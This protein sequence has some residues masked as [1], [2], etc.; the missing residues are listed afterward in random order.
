VR[1]FLEELASTEPDTPGTWF[2]LGITLRD[3]GLLIGDCGIRF[4]A[5]ESWQVEIGITLAPQHQGNGYATEALESILAYCFG[6]LG[7]HRVFASVDPRNGA[8]I[9]LLERLGMR[10]EAH[11]RE[12][13]WFKGAWA[14]DLIYAILDHE[15]PGR[16][17]PCD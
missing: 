11:F 13:L 7:K 10:R 8:S 12:S 14:D 9:T 3:S 15:W 2:Q 1:R 17:C 6:P 16:H 5:E 4:P